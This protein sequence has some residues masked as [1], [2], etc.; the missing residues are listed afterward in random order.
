MHGKGLMGLQKKNRS[1]SVILVLPN[2]VRTKTVRRAKGTLSNYVR[3]E[4]EG[5]RPEIPLGIGFFYWSEYAR[6]G[7]VLLAVKVGITVRSGSGF[8]AASSSASL[9][10]SRLSFAP[11]NQTTGNRYTDPV[12]NIA[13]PSPS[14]KILE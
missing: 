12:T 14:F 11:T 5:E 6:R 9:I 8:A 3:K 4:G 2:G 10:S 13:I 1:S 7:A